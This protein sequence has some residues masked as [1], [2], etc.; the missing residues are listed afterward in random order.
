[1]KDGYFWFNFVKI[2]EVRVSQTDNCVSSLEF[3]IF[4][5]C[6][7]VV[8]GELNK[9]MAVDGFGWVNAVVEEVREFLFGEVIGDV[10]LEEMF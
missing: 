1:V 3:D 2:L 8:I 6:E 4:F 5:V 10:I 7:F 9:F